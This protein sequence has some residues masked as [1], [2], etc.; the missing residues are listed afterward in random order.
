MNLTPHQYAIVFAM[1]ME[2]IG[3]TRIPNRAIEELQRELAHANTAKRKS[4]LE[5]LSEMMGIADMKMSAADRIRI[6]ASLAEQGLPA[7]TE[8]ADYFERGQNAILPRVLSRGS[9]SDEEE[10]GVVTKE[11]GDLTSDLTEE[12]RIRLGDMINRYESR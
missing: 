5:S 9:I 6:D 1:T 11:L 10:M 7:Y 3:G 12:Q 4:I 8:L 2:V